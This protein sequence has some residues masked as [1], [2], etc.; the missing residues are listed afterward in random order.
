MQN[1]FSYKSKIFIGIF[2]FLT[3]A[4][5]IAWERP[6]SK[7]TGEPLVKTYSGSFDLGYAH[8]LNSPVYSADTLSLS[9][10]FAILYKQNIL[11][12]INANNLIGTNRPKGTVSKNIFTGAS[13][14]VLGGY[15]FEMTDSFDINL[16]LGFGIGY[17]N[18][19]YINPDDSTKHTF[20]G[21]LVLKIPFRTEFMY[22]ITDSFKVGLV[23]FYALRWQNDFFKKSD[24]RL[25]Q[26]MGALVSLK[27]IY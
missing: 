20:S 13:V 23:P 26:E 27:Y 3:S 19:F 24:W 5:S 2:L 17:E 15:S 25:S 12:W 11:L 10:S 9:T 22:K 4:I 7:Y 6:S 1:F 18:A 16:G 8:I 14:E 21:N